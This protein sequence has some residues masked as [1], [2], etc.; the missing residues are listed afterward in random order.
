MKIFKAWRGKHGIKVPAIHLIGDVVFA[1]FGI[2]VVLIMIHSHVIT[3]FILH[4]I[5][6]S[7]G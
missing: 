3:D 4:V 5:S 2:K 7:G 6:L 1:L